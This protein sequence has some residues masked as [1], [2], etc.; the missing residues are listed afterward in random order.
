M[1][2]KTPLTYQESTLLAYLA[3]GQ[4]LSDIFEIYFLTSQHLHTQ[5]IMIML[6]NYF[7]FGW[8]ATQEK[9]SF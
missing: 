7:V 6:S 4:L 9:E 1:W 3:F 5:Y 8:S 2:K